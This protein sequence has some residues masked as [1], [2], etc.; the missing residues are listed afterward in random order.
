MIFRYKTNLRR[1]VCLEIIG[2]CGLNCAHCSS[3]SS[4]EN[5]DYLS[6]D[7]IKKVIVETSELGYNEL[8]LSGGDPFLHPHLIDLISY[9]KEHNFYVIAYSSGNI[10]DGN[11]L[12]PI[13]KNFFKKIDKA[14]LDKIVFSIHGLSKQ[15]HEQITQIKN[16]Y[17]NLLITLENSLNGYQFEKEVNFVFMKNNSVELFD[18]IPFLK[19]YQIKNLH[20]LKYVAHGRAKE[21]RKKYEIN[22]IEL[23][24]IVLRFI[25]QKID[26]IGISLSS[27]LPMLKDDD[28]IN[29]RAGVDKIC[30]TPTGYVYPCVAMKNFEGFN[31]FN[32][33]NQNSIEKIIHES[34]IFKFIN[35]LHNSS[36]HLQCHLNCPAQKIIKEQMI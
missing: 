34:R 4:I 20:L 5:N 25:S 15:I 13:S 29:C 12:V 30:I 9:A 2:K 16:S 10:L 8:S 1:V 31:D 11:K 18:I 6:L 7:Q 27:S 35:I 24:D 3:N 17:E 22:D 23:K 33:I 28:R 14:G 32:N 19:L 36:N 26:K 21:N